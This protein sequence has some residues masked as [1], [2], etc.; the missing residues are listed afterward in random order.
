MTFGQNTWWAYSASQK[1]TLGW[2][3]EANINQSTINQYFIVCPKV[4]HR[5]GQ[6][7]VP[8]V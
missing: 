6:L 4:D 1:P 3:Y 7:S 8:C 2:Q 5:A